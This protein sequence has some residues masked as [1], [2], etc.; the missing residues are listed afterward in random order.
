MSPDEFSTLDATET[1]NLIKRGEVSRREVVEA[2]IN[3]IEKINPLLNAVV[4]TCFDEA[5]ALA[6]ER[7]RNPDDGPFSGVPFLLKDMGTSC[8]GMPST[9]GS[10]FVADFRPEKDD[11]LVSRY[12]ATG[13]LVLGKTNVPELG[14]VAVTESALFGPARNPW[15]LAY[16]PGGSSGGSAAAVAAG[17]VPVA[18][19]G[20]GGGSIRNPASACGL[21]GLKPTRARISQGPYS[22]EVMGGLSNDHVLSRS[23]RDSAAFLDLT[24]GPL[25]G[26]P[27]LAPANHR[28]WLEAATSD[29]QPLKIAVC[30]QSFKAETEVAPDVVKACQRV[31]QTLE[32]LGHHVEV[33]E[34]GPV[35]DRIAA[36]LA[37]IW[38][39]SVAANLSALGQIAGRPATVDDV[40]PL[41]WAMF[42]RSKQF[43]S[44]DYYQAW[45]SVYR[46]GYRLARTLAPYDVLLTPTVTSAPPKVGTIRTDSFEYERI[47]KEQNP[48]SG[49]TSLFNATG[50]PA[51]SLPAGLLDNGLPIGV[52]I[53]G[54]YGDEDTLFSLAGQLERACPWSGLRPTL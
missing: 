1:A 37:T 20:D 30:V 49:F 15:D 33:I 26:D 43:S 25:A 2:A 23:V 42:E 35:A 44:L 18:H 19:A 16:S 8:V 47:S 28:T 9:F 48:Y 11:L 5:L 45:Q 27:Y 52:Q 29:P 7:D 24:A 40:E 54:R 46:F 21:V 34:P 13:A 36:P 32:G 31:A 6:D 3:R 51:M 12:K 50:Q 38:C 53:V 22:G 4:F 17:L 10:K 41:T 14:L 39:T